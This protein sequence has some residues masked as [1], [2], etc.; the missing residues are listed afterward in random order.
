VGNGGR[1][2]R[3]DDQVH[4]GVAEGDRADAAVAHDHRTAAL[5]RRAPVGVVRAGGVPA[6]DRAPAGTAALA[7]QDG[8]VPVVAVGRA[9]A[10]GP[11]GLLAD[12]ERLAGAVGAGDLRQGLVAAG[13]PGLPDL[14]PDLA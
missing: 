10:V 3:V 14:R 5:E 6:D 8:L 11:P 7:L 9:V 4:V 12:H 2:R 1:V 13:L